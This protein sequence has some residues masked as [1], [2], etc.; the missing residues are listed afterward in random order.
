MDVK[1]Q[2]ME[3][4]VEGKA[5]LMYTYCLSALHTFTDACSPAIAIAIARPTHTCQIHFLVPVFV[6]HATDD[7]NSFPNVVVVEHSAL[8]QCLKGSCSYSIWII[9]QDS[10][11]IL[12]QEELGSLTPHPRL[13]PLPMG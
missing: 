2:C 10:A 8:S 5:L 6:A 9:L 12:N 13:N 7:I 3:A 11:P 4:V 1:L